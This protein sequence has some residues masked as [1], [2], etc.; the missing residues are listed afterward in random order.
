MYGRSYGC[1]VPE[2]GAVVVENGGQNRKEGEERRGV[3]ATARQLHII[4]RACEFAPSMRECRKCGAIKRD[5]MYDCEC[6]TKM[7]TVDPVK[8][9]KQVRRELTK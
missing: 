3:M 9:W 1:R 4:E 8:V 6:G 2:A 7:V 5:R